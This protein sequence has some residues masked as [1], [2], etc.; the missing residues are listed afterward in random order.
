MAILRFIL[1]NRFVYQNIQFTFAYQSDSAAIK[2]RDMKKKPIFAVHFWGGITGGSAV[3]TVK[4][5]N[6]TEAKRK[7]LKRFT[8]K[9]SASI[10]DIDLLEEGHKHFSILSRHAI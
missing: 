8:K 3:Q 9:T 2:N 4:A 10:I 7:F 6:K 5:I 1:D